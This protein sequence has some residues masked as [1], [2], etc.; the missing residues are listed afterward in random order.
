MQRCALANWQLHSHHQNNVLECSD[1][2]FLANLV[3][4]GLT[5]KQT[6]VEA[7]TLRKSRSYSSP[8]IAQ[9]IEV[10]LRKEKR[11]HSLGNSS[12]MLLEHPLEARKRW[13]W[14]N[15][16]RQEFW[17]YLTFQRQNSTDL[18][19]LDSKMHL[20]SLNTAT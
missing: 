4:F 20:F 5:R 16:E 3:Y 1:S 19:E 14:W 7:V 10:N 8:K 11:S 15:T 2:E 9:N 13:Y 6:P 12:V 18:L 17:P